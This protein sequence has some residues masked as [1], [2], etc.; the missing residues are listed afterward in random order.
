ME[1]ESGVRRGALVDVLCGDMAGL[2]RATVRRLAAWLE[3]TVEAVRQLDTSHREQVRMAREAE[4]EEDWP[5]GLADAGMLSYPEYIL[6]ICRFEIHVGCGYEQCL[7]IH[8]FEYFIHIDPG[9]AAAFD[10]IQFPIHE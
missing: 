7:F 2:S 1:R 5:T 6:D 8:M 10:H 4:R 3:W 9:F